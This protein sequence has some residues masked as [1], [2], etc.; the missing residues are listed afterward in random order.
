MT[1]TSEDKKT[2]ADSLKEQ[3]SD[4]YEIDLYEL[5]IVLWNQKWL[6][7]GATT[8]AVLAA[9]AY[10]FIATPL[11]EITMQVRPPVLGVYKGWNTSD[12]ARWINEKQY[13][14]LLDKLSTEQEEIKIL[15][16]TQG[17]SQIVTWRLFYPDP[18]EG[19]RILNL[20]YN[21]ACDFYVLKGGDPS[22]A[23]TKSELEQKIKNLEQEISSIDLLELPNLD[24]M[25]EAK[26]QEQNLLSKIASIIAQEKEI[27]YKT[28]QD[29][30]NL[31]NKI[32]G[33]STEPIKAMTKVASSNDKIAAFILSQIAEQTMQYEGTLVNQ[34]AERK[35][36]ALEKEQEITSLQKQI[37]ILQEEVN[38]LKY[39]K[40][41]LN[42][43]KEDLSREIEATKFKLQHLRPFE[44]ISGPIASLKPEKPKK[45][46]V[47]A[48]AGALGIFLGIMLA[49]LN[50]G[51]RKRLQNQKG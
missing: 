31:L 25:I 21:K 24:F 18:D 15:A 1:E 12:I 34:I 37:L 50:Y 32:S 48:V 43:K 28:S 49:F 16:S 22:A 19:K 30:S 11:Y 27:S 8:I 41:Q 38:E 4:D 40:G 5:L 7:L 10:L 47:L 51:W 13:L 9:L 44:K 23:Q 36:V 2:K 33:T 35:I 42:L 3:I 39:K 26:T 46:L 6:I 14:G 17:D 29:L 45:L 20:I